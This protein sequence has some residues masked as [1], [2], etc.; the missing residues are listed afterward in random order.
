VINL[1]SEVRLH[2]PN[3]ALLLVRKVEYSIN[4]SGDMAVGEAVCLSIYSHESIIYHFFIF[5]M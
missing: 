1:K 3:F 2:I 5:H 4:W